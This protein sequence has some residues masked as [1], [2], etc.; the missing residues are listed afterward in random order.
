MNIA[1]LLMDILG[2]SVILKPILVA[3]SNSSVKFFLMS[4]LQNER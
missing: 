2:S 4:L 3:I 1:L